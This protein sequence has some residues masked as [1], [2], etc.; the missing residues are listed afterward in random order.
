MATSTILTRGVT[1]IFNISR[2]L[3]LR[4]PLALDVNGTSLVGNIHEWIDNYPL[5]LWNATRKSK[6]NIN[7]TRDAHFALKQKIT[8]L[9][10]EI[11]Q[12]NVKKKLQRLARKNVA[13]KLRRGQSLKIVR[14]RDMKST[15]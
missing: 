9:Y 10:P 11:I 5:E 3:S 2:R 4:D 14:L 12:A 6:C 13:E 1:E 8:E 15:A 7:L